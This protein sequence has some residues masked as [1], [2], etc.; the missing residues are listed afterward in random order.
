VGA[1]SR[2]FW[3]GIGAFFTEKELNAKE[4]RRPQ[5]ERSQNELTQDGRTQIWS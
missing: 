2:A 4:E 3:L 1:L 5:V